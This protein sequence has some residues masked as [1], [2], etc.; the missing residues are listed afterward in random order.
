[1]HLNNHDWYISE[2]GKE[3]AHNN[4]TISSLIKPKNSVKF[5]IL[6]EDVVLNLDLSPVP[7][8]SIDKVPM[9]VNPK[10]FPPIIGSLLSPNKVSRS[11]E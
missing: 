6:S 10:Q 1:M 11:V 5:H 4:S 2:T 7:C 9:S 8:V 3:F